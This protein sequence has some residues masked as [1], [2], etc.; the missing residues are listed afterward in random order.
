MPPCQNK[1]LPFYSGSTITRCY[2][3]VLKAC[4]GWWRMRA[5]TWKKRTQPSAG[6]LKKSDK[7]AMRG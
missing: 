7:W 2:V 3:P 5:A 4:S 6:R 1:T